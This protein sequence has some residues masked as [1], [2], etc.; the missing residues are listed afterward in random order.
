MRRS[1]LALASLPV[2]FASGAALAANQDFTIVNKT[3]Y[4]IDSIYVS[5]ANNRSWGEDVMGRDA[6]ADGESVHI[7]FP[8]S[9]DTCRWDLKVKYNDGDESTWGNVNLCQ[10]SRV[11]LFWDR[12]ANQTRAQAE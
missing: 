12:N 8:N 11:S 9:T 1:L 7:T 5:A 2:L 6:L 10:I 4:Q 3:G